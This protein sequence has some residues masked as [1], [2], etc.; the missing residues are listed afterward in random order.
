M[1]LAEIGT[2]RCRLSQVV[3]RA[4]ARLKGK[5]KKAR[6]QAS[7]VGG[8]WRVRP[9]GQTRAATVVVEDTCK[10]SRRRRRSP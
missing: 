3:K 8:V 7:Y 5:E 10:T 4:R 1:G 2:P 6:L 9:V